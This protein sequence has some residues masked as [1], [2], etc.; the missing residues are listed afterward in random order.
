MNL[1]TDVPAWEQTIRASVEA[2]SAVLRTRGQGLSLADTLHP[3]ALVDAA[4]SQYREI[5]FSLERTEHQKDREL[6]KAR[7]A[8]SDANA[9]IHFYR[10]A[11]RSSLSA[12]AELTKGQP[13]GAELQ[14]LLTGFAPPAS[15]CSFLFLPEGTVVKPGTWAVVRV[16]GAH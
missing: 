8:L 9:G 12:I 4:L 15:Y 7:Q 3:E 10:D 14:A 11:L 6:A 13:G 2:H 5:V 1:P 16:D